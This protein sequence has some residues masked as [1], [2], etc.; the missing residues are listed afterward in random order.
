MNIRTEKY[1]T[2]IPLAKNGRPDSIYQYY[3]YKNH[4]FDGI[5]FKDNRVLVLT[6][7]FAEIK[8]NVILNKPSF[9]ILIRL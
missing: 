7:F 2:D 9:N 6:P 8:L 5:N 1:P 3:Y 4:Y